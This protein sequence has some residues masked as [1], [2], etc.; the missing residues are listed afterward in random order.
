MSSAENNQLASARWLLDRGADINA[1]MH[2]TRWSAL[3]A[4]AKQ[5]N[6]AMVKLLLDKGANRAVAAEHREYGKKCL[7]VD[8]TTNQAVR[9][10]LSAAPVAAVAG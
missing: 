10:L 6:L 3:H 7:P 8:V 2:A 5:S 9:E 1:C 4:A